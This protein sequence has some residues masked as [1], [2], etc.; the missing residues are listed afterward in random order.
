MLMP[1]TKRVLYSIHPEVLSRFN[2]LFKGRDRSRAIESLML[3]AINEREQEVVAAA[4]LIETDPAFSEY[5]E[6]SDWADAQAVDTL[7]TF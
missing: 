2:A 3:K 4:K 7:A 5:H 1:T 6:V